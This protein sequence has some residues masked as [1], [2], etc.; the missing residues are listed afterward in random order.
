MGNDTSCCGTNEN[1]TRSGGKITYDGKKKRHVDAKKK[2]RRDATGS[3]T[4]SQSTGTCSLPTNT[5][6]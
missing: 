1:K 3:S 4:H 6:L 2:A 5:S